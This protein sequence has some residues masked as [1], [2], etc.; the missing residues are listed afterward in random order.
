MH[1]NAHRIETL[2]AAIAKHDPAAIAACYTD[3][4]TFED[5]AFR[6]NGREQIHEMWRLVCHAKPKVTFGP[7][8]ADNQRGAGGWKA[9]YMFGASDTDPGRR[10]VNSLS[11]EFTFSGGLIATHRD[12]C[13]TVAWAKQAYPFPKWLVAAYVAPLRRLAAA[14]KLKKFLETHP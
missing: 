11:S 2:Y 9:D 5:I 8:L 6:R 10:V 12:A 14:R 4:A 7:V 3:D 1:P 13:D